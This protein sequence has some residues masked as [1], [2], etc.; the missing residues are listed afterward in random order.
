MEYI[1]NYDSIIVYNG[2]PISLSGES[3]SN[4][5]GLLTSG[6][7]VKTD[8]YNPALLQYFVYII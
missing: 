5:T 8:V 1:N 2:D 4:I 6:L 3:H 7:S